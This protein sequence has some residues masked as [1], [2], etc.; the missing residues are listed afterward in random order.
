MEPGA[1]VIWATRGG[2]VIGLAIL[3]AQIV[4]SWKAVGGRKA[5]AN[6][7][8]SLGKLAPFVFGWLYGA[9]GVLTVMGFI[10]WAFDAVL[11]ISNWLGDAALVLGVGAEAGVSSRG[12]YLPLTAD[13]SGLVLI[14][15][16][17]FLTAVKLLKSGRDLKMGAWCGACLGT[18][19]GIA[20][21]LAVPLAQATNQLGFYLFGWIG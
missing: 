15:T 8:K 21:A 12:N 13:G 20:G 7:V 10:G 11:W 3:A 5:L 9:L 14:L 1:G 19:S 18:S 4:I 2:I 6:P 16:A 17:A